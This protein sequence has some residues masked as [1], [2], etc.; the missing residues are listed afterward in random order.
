MADLEPLV[1]MRKHLVEQ[2]Q[3]FL[4]DLYRQAEELQKEKFFLI[5][6]LKDERA[7]VDAMNSV[8]AVVYF[9]RY[10]EVIKGR[11]EDIDEASAKMEARIEVAR[12][13]IRNSFAELKKVEIVQERREEEEERARNKKESQT[14]D[15]TA[16]EGY[17]RK[18][19]EK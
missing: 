18:Q 4:A 19:E 12:E 3:K 6:Q 10:S 5:K 2:K 15:E 8:E 16:I 9:G 17:R 13:D 7:A 11:I 1:R 14:L